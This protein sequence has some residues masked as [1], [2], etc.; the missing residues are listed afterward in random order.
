MHQDGQASGSHAKE[1][2]LGSERFNGSGEGMVRLF[3][4]ISTLLRE[5]PSTHVAI[6]IEGVERY[7]STPN[8]GGFTSQPPVRLSILVCLAWELRRMSVAFSD[9]DHLD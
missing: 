2:Q 1:E 7:W 3:P 8:P 9:C 4:V 5:R 6:S